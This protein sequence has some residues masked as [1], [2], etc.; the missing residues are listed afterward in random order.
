MTLRHWDVKMDVP[1]DLVECY[2]IVHIRNF[3]FILQSDD[4]Q[5]VLG[6]LMRLIRT[7]IFGGLQF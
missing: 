5:C 7:L 4:I 6:N 2:D 3:A 1:E